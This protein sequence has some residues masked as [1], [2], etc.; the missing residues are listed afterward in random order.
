[1][2]NSKYDVNHLG[3]LQ[4]KAFYMVGNISKR[5][6]ILP[7]LFFALY[8]ILIPFDNVIWLTKE[9]GTVTKYLGIMTALAIL[10]DRIVVGRGHLNRPP[11]GSLLWLLFG[12]L[13]IFSLI[14]SIDQDATKQGL[15]TLIG[16][17]IVLF[18]VTLQPWELKHLRMIERSIIVGGIIVSIIA[19]YIFFKDIFYPSSERLS[20]V[21]GKR[22]VDPNHLGASLILPISFA[23]SLSLRRG[24]I[25]FFNLT[26]FFLMVITVILTGSRGVLAG[27][28]IVLLYKYW[29][30]KK[31][32]FTTILFILIVA[33][34]IIFI[35]RILSPYLKERYSLEIIFSSQAAGRFPLWK[36]ALSAFWKKP[37][38]GWGY[39]C[40]S[41]LTGGTLYYLKGQVAHNIY[42]QALSEL[43]IVGLFFLIYSLFMTYRTSSKNARK[44]NFY[45]SVTAAL[46]GIAV[47]SI[48]LGTLNYKYF[49]LANMLAL[50]M[51]K[52]SCD[53]NETEPFPIFITK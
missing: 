47:V 43:G 5:T 19:I 4:N 7:V 8:A 28:S 41:K 34:A 46:L 17:I 9:W 24:K 10:A 21:L 42:L 35:P 38:L 20:L 52:T 48:S 18:I 33:L 16:L 3:K 30:I 53:E 6:S 2:L 51:S 26:A 37:I 32:F 40:F 1:M 23:L 25:L 14:W 31:E 29:R 44:N 27:L 22:L 11:Y 13:A 15:I 36:A 39:A 45:E 49:W 50:S 12:I